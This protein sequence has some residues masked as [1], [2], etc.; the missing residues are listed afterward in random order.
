MGRGNK[1]IKDLSGA[2][3][4]ISLTKNKLSFLPFQL[5]LWKSG[6]FSN[7]IFLRTILNNGPCSLIKVKISSNTIPH[8]FLEKIIELRCKVLVGGLKSYVEECRDICFQFNFPTQILV[9]GQKV[10]TSSY[11]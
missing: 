8:Q 2:Y 3:Y 11:N 5:V 7:S 6:A 4:Y 10:H 1:E 9:Y